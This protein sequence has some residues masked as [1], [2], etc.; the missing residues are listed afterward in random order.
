MGSNPL[1]QLNACR[2]G[3]CCVAEFSVHILS[4]GS[5]Q[6]VLYCKEHGIGKT[7]PQPDDVI[8]HELH[9]TQY[10]RNGEGERFT[11]PVEC[12]VEGMRRWRIQRLSRF[13]KKGRALDIGCGSGRFLRALR[14]SGWEVAG[15]E[16]NDDTATAAR[17][18]HGL[19]VETSLDGFSD[20]SFD[21][22]TITH[23]LEHIRDPDQLLEECVRLLRP[24][25][26]IAVAVP[27]IDSWQA[28]MTR[29][30]WFHLDLP[31]HL[32]HFSEKW[33]CRKM[34]DFDYEQVSVRRLDLAHNV[35]GWLQSLLNLL[36]L[37]HNRFYTFL[38]NDE[39]ERE[40]RSHYCSLFISL[41][42]LPILLPLSTLLA[43][44]EVLFHSSG[45]VEIVARV[46]S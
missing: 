1:C 27:N 25:G 4:D 35:F 37:R 18:V 11:R 15:L 20:T 7:D 33:L 42:L 6:R 32:W 39:L 31:R 2:I 43:V 23:V 22:I 12:L 24:G 44:V 19:I 38:K 45:T 41:V 36:G 34:V 10:Y 29:G 13:V 3:V 30:N 16:L 9:S 40:N 46:K 14:G 17:A 21:L 8:L 26:V 28:R 5:S